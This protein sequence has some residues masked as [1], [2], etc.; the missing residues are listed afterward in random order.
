MSPAFE[1]SDDDGEVIEGFPFGWWEVS[2][3]RS[4]DY[5]Q[6]I[7]LGAAYAYMALRRASAEKDTMFLAT[8]VADLINSREFGPLEAG[9]IAKLCDAAR[10]G[11]MN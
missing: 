9:F 7:N 11:A 1:I 3:Q 6:D 4:G 2:D 10:A 8:M 5:E